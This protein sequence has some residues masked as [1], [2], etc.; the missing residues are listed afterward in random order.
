MIP[1]C[2]HPCAQKLLSWLLCAHEMGTFVIYGQN[3]DCSICVVM[4]QCF[5]CL[6]SPNTAGGMVTRGAKLGSLGMQIARAGIFVTAGYYPEN[7]PGVKSAQGSAGISG[8]NLSPGKN[9]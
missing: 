1:K 7:T 9:S 4:V 6:G 2:V 8:G 3:E 5:K